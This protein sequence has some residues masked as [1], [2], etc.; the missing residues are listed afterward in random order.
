MIYSKYYW[1]ILQTSTGWVIPPSMSNFPSN[2]QHKL[3]NRDVPCTSSAHDPDS[4]R[5]CMF[6]DG[7]LGY[8]VVC[9]GRE[10]DLPT[11]CPGRAM[12]EVERELVARQELNWVKP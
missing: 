11:M 1:I 9:T 4:T 10:A 3:I 8:C 12:S 6:C 2:T 7:G 5:N